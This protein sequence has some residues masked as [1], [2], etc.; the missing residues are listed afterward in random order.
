[1]IPSQKRLEGYFPGHGANLRAILDGRKDPE[2][3]PA[4]RA[5]IEQ[6]YNRPRESEL[7]ERALEE[8]LGAYRS[9]AIE[10]NTWDRF[11]LNI[12]AIY[13]NMGDTYATTLLFDVNADKW[14]ITTYGDWVER[15]SKKYEIQ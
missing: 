2:T 3:Y 5:W 13:L 7:I 12:V 11:Y 6:C 14:V 15:Y 10:G 1:M 9:E 4:V 8:E